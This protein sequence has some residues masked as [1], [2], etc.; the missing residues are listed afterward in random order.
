[1]RMDDSQLQPSHP[2]GAPEGAAASPVTESGVVGLSLVGRRLRHYTIV[3]RLGG[4]AMAAV[5]RAAD[6]RSGTFVALKVLLADADATMRERFA[7]EARMAASLSHPHIVRTLDVG[8]ADAGDGS[9]SAGGSAGGIAYMVMELVEGESLGD[10]LERVHALSMTDSCAVLAPIARALAYAHEQGVVHRDVKPSNILLRRA[11]PGTPNSVR[12]TALDYPVTPLLSDFGIARALDAPELT[13]A[14]RTIGTPAYMSP[15][16]CAGSRAIDGRADIYSLGVVLYRCLAGRPPFLGTTTQ[17]LYAHVYE[18]VLL[19]DEVLRTLSPL[20]MELLRR[21]LTKEPGQRYATAAALAQDLAQAGGAPVLAGGEVRP[22]RPDEGTATMPDME[23]LMPGRTTTSSVIV[24]A[25]SA[26]PSAPAGAGQKQPAPPAVARPAAPRPVQVA[27]AASAASAPRPAPA[28]AARPAWIGSALGIA[29]FL[30]VIG[31]GGGVALALLLGGPPAT[32]APAATFTP[33]AP[34]DAAL[35]PPAATTPAATAATA[36]AIAATAATAATAPP[37][38]TGDGAAVATAPPAPP[39]AAP[40]L[41]PTLTPTG[42]PTATATPRATPA[43]DIAAYWQ[44]AQIAFDEADWS[45]AADFLT[46]VQR[47]DPNYERRDVGDLVALASTAL[48]AQAAAGGDFAEAVEQYK[49]ALDLRPAERAV[50]DLRA[51]ADRLVQAGEAAPEELRREA[52]VLFAGYARELAGAG[53]PCVALAQLGAAR[54]LAPDPQLDAAAEEVAAAC[55]ADVQTRRELNALEQLPGRLYY[56]TQV[57]DAYQVFAM[58][59]QPDAGSALV[60][61]NASQPALAPDG[62][63][64]AINSRRTDALGLA[65]FDLA[66]GLDPNSRSVMYTRAPED[67]RDAPADWNPAG[68]ALVYASTSAGDRRSRVYT[69]ATS[70][71]DGGSTDPRSTRYGQSPAWSP[72]GQWIVYNGIDDEGQRAGLWLM[73]P[74]GSDARPLTDRASDTRPAWLP[75]GSG[76]VFMGRDR[77]ANWELYRLDLA[78]GAIARLTDDAAQDGLPAVSPDGAFVA[79]ASDRG[80]VWR[81]WVV[82]T[83]GGSAYPLATLAGQLTN[84]LEHALVWAAGE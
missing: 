53:Q 13:N 69:V 31:V 62:R 64:L 76:I 35:V 5:Y 37:S 1:M 7:M 21:T 18:P 82:P 34:T 22:A 39:T 60:V 15:E 20:V 71:A 23:T 58:P 70:T 9:G 81:V 4:G 83:A 17:I 78:S 56:S 59:M 74:D 26:A 61:D 19:P 57:G 43:G 75:D 65:G 72:D 30:L 3:E 12:L 11:A 2:A 51:A 49:R 29:L 84:W 6:D 38:A 46:I 8:G 45:T 24:P 32:P 79:F 44:E 77:D 27:P 80:G 28:R 48:A 66:A 16:Q 55:A 52:Q 40:T 50:R 25:L 14:G 10:L 67:A 73:R 68:S 33:P 36:N 63:T 42:T 47:I 54:A 41:T